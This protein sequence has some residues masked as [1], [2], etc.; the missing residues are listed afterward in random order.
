MTLQRPKHLTVLIWLIV[1]IPLIFDFSLAFKDGYELLKRVIFTTVIICLGLAMIVL[2]RLQGWFG[3]FQLRRRVF[4]PPVLLFAAAAL[5]SNIAPI[6]R[7]DGMEM[8]VWL[9]VLLLMYAM[10]GGSAD[11]ERDGLSILRLLALSGMVVGIY[12]VL[13]GFSIDLPALRGNYDSISTLGHRNVA[14]QSLLLLLPAAVG[15]LLLSAGGE[16]WL[17]GLATL[18]MSLHLLFTKSRGAWLGFLAELVIAVLVITLA[19]GRHTRTRPNK[20]AEING[21]VNRFPR[22]VLIVGV[23]IVIIL[24]FAAGQGYSYLGRFASSFN[25]SHGTAQFRLLT[26]KSTLEMIRDYPVFGVGL[27]S[28]GKAFP[29]YRNPREI[30]FS[31]ESTTV[32]KTHN[33]HLQFWAEMGLVGLLAWLFL[34]MC[35]ARVGWDLM[36]VEAASPLH[37]LSACLLVACGGI[38]VH[39]L[40]SFGLAF[41]KASM[42]VFWFYLSLLGVAHGVREKASGS[43]RGFI[44]RLPSPWARVTAAGLAALAV[45]FLGYRPLQGARLFR[46]GENLRQREQHELAVNRFIAAAKLIP[47]DYR[48]YHQLAYSYERLGRLDEAERA[49]RRSIDLFPL[50]RDGYFNLGYLYESR[51]D[52]DNAAD[53]YRKALELYPENLSATNNLVV[54]LQRMEKLD[55]AMA[56]AR[57]GLLWH[58]YSPDLNNNL[59]VC[60]FRMHEYEEAARC[61]QRVVELRRIIV[62]PRSTVTHY[63]L[64]GEIQ[65]RISGRDR[66]GAMVLP[67]SDW[68]RLIFSPGAGPAPEVENPRHGAI[69]SWDEDNQVLVL[70]FADDERVDTYLVEYELKGVNGSFPYRQTEFVFAKAHNNLGQCLQML[71]RYQ[72]ASHEYDASIALAPQYAN[73]YCNAAGMHFQFT[74]DMDKAIWYYKGCEKIQGSATPE[75]LRRFAAEAGVD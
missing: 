13:Q 24:A 18:C 7:H 71:G 35:L 25:T 61:F 67:P 36:R 31:G 38:L 17:A 10:V 39:S 4:D 3:G 51:K 47:A 57:E 30:D 23:V 8:L 52:W 49:E 32:E 19:A 2:P 64:L 37:T 15:W 33:D 48:L 20:G 69:F 56:A 14:A 41:S 68:G 26:W 43:S 12:G 29:R 58:P 74:R 75:I 27:G 42:V 5:L 54:V 9:A 50:H 40:F 62:F 34:L 16:R 46:Q 65:F 6:N 45:W 72:E 59:G 22:H 66:E 70:T 73:P 11:L 63:A 55:E 53:Y 44:L 28:F 1:L 60:Y 21:V